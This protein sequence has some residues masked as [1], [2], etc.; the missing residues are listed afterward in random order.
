MNVLA[1][2]LGTH[3][4]WALRCGL[5][6]RVGQ[7][8]LARG[9]SRVFRSPIPMVRLWHRLHLL[10]RLVQID[11]IV[12]EG[13][14]SR[15]NPSHHLASLETV[16]TLFACEGGRRWLRVNPSTWKKVV[17]GHGRASIDEYWAFARKAWPSLPVTTDNK[18][19]ALCLLH[20]W[21][22]AAGLEEIGHEAD[23]Q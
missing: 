18:A 22:F 19:A 4:G 23:L 14:F 8:H 12:F 15:G 11:T 1:L 13:T 20:Y 7:W 6:T 10:E 21:D 17:I 9:Q 2:D 3:T 5:T 16:T